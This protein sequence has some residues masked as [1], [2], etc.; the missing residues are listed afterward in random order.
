MRFNRPIVLLVALLLLL[1]LLV[2]VLLVLCSKDEQS[3]ESAVS[4]DTASITDREI[5]PAQANDEVQQNS[6]ENTDKVDLDELQSQLQQ[7][8]ESQSGS[9]SVYVKDISSGATAQ[10]E[11]KKMKAASLIK[12]FV[13]AAVYEKMENGQL[14]QTAE[15]DDLLRDMITISHNESTNRLVA[16]LGDGDFAAGM[17]QVNEY[18]QRHGYAD[19]EQQRD[20][21]DWRPEP[22]PEENYTSVR[23][24]GLLLERIYSGAC[25]SKEADAEMLDLLLA[26]T[27]VGKIPAGLPEG[28]KVAN[29]TGELSDTENDAA[30]VFGPNR[31]YI[32]CVISNDLPETEAARTAI[33]S[34]SGSVYEYLDALS[35]TP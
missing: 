9:W 28:T 24:C 35:Q 5:I 34:I 1:L 3:L 31:D 7:T 19:T 4:L 12:L 15:T 25:V 29:K 27:R 20:L 33:V 26:Q 10:I 21:R 2:A 17:A 32:L 22:I 30:I 14:E 23:D 16:L 6:E 13:M 8:L 11:S 18:C